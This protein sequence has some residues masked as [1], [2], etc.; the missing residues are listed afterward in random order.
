MA[1]MAGPLEDL[2][3]AAL[4]AAAGE[5]KPAAYGTDR[6]GNTKPRD[7]YRAQRIDD[8]TRQSIDRWDFSKGGTVEDFCAKVRG[9]QGDPGN[10]PYLQDCEAKFST[11]FSSARQRYAE[12]VAQRANAEKEEADRQLAAQREEERKAALG[13]QAAATREADLRAGRVKPQN[14]GEVAIAHNAEIGVDLASAPKIRP[15]GKLYA[16]PGKIAK[17]K[18]ESPEFVAQLT[19]GEQNDALF[20]MTGRGSEIN[21]R[22]F[23]V[24]IPKALQAYYF[25]QGRIGR[26]FDL[27]GRYVANTKYTTLAKEEKAAPVFEAVYFVMWQ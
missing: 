27:V 15:D 13:K 14:L 19:L 5:N 2:L 4:K 17:D 18:G 12:S 11:D 23:Y 22:Y 10:L 7:E 25:D 24:R 9:Q 1:V 16:L 21:H 26:G 6:N 8:W 20:R 3:G